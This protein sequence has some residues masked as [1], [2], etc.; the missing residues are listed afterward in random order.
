M[1][2]RG[3]SEKKPRACWF[4]FLFRMEMEGLVAEEG[5]EVARG[6]VER[7][8]AWLDWKIVD[9]LWNPPS[10][11]CAGLCSVPAE[12]CPHRI[13]YCTQYF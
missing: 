6:A 9:E 3:K 5:G 11:P 1:R 8:V 13:Q 7:W 2:R 12:P 4:C 10:S